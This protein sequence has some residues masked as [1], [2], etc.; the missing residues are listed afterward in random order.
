MRRLRYLSIQNFLS[1][2]KLVQLDLLKRG[3]VG[4]EG[5][6]KDD[7]S[8]VN[9]GSG[10]TT[11][12]ID[13]IQWCLFGITSRGYENDD[14]I[15]NRATRECYV[16]LIIME[17]ET[18]IT[19]TRYRK[20]SEFKNSINVNVD[21]KDLSKPSTKETQEVIN[22]LLGMNADTFINSV[23]FGG[24]PGYRFSALTDK[25]QKEVFDDALG[26]AQYAQACDAARKELH[27]AQNRYDACSKDYAHVHRALEVE[28]HR[29][30]DLK[31]KE[32]QFDKERQKRVLVIQ[33]DMEIYD[34]R[35]DRLKRGMNKEDLDTG[36]LGQQIG[37]AEFYHDSMIGVVSKAKFKLD[38]QRKQVTRLKAQLAKAR[39]GEYT[40]AEC[41][42]H[43][44]KSTCVHI[45]E[46]IKDA[47]ID[48]LQL[49]RDLVS[50]E[51][52][53]KKSNKTLSKAKRALDQA[54]THNEE[55]T[56]KRHK[57]QLAK[58][59]AWRARDMYNEARKQRNPYGE[60]LA[61]CIRQIR[62][63]ETDVIEHKQKMEKTE[64]KIEQLEFWVS[65][66]GTKG[67]R[68]YLI[69]TALP[70]LNERAEHYATILTDGTATIEF[71]TQSKQ[72]NGAIVDRFEVAVNNKY[73]ASN[74]KGNSGGEK[75]KVDL[76]V[77]LALQDLV[78][79]RSKTRLNVAFF[80][81]CF[82]RLDE[83][84]VE[85]AVNVL[86]EVA[87][88]RESVF[89]VTHLE[90]LKSYFPSTITVQK[91]RGATKLLEAT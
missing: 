61:K 24:T 47:I 29:E 16:Q 20:H 23:M 74:Y 62:Q 27:I 70:F 73:G 17:K 64:K 41:G 18:V 46:R 48:E 77:G 51:R 34:E 54:V 56:R 28:Q 3:L 67:V 4:V 83:A 66:Y 72:K 84:G 13:A 21:G 85:R 68:S 26:I 12:F 78:M 59:D 52:D 79:S 14:V 53:V 45:K 69:D 40:C 2:G 57:L 63:L 65:A 89:V 33:K 91:K 6:N 82:D 8:A 87:K 39:K 9:N 38:L 50:A 11:I 37:E 25:Q 60:L 31:R 22:K 75:A 86:Q 88:E 32:R 42:S 90:A 30:K 19:V 36:F 55:Y 81:E 80:D 71:R 35:V 58:K 76:C 10:K 1:V 15:H 5:I 7:P 43:V 44:G 49:E